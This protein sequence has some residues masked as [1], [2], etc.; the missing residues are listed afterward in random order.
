MKVKESFYALVMVKDFFCVRVDQDQSPFVEE[1]IQISFYDETPVVA[2]SLQME[3]HHV[4]EWVVPPLYL[5]C[6]AEQGTV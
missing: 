4:G 1:E 6:P 5:L 3:T 2:T